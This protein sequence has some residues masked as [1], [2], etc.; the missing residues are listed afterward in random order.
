MRIILNLL[1]LVVSSSLIGQNK[2]KDYTE[3]FNLIEV[4]LDA[5]KDYD[6][7]PGITLAVIDDQEVM[8]SGAFGKASIEDDV[9]S[10]TRTLGSI[11]SISKLFT[12]VAIMKLYDEGKIRLDDNIEDLLPWF[13][14]QQQYK[15][16]GPIT[17]RSLMTHSSGL[18]R[19]A[20]APY[21]TGPDFPF[22]SQEEVKEGL[23]NQ[24]TLYPAS[25]YSQYSNLG[26][27]LLGE[28]V[29]E[30]SGM[31]YDEYINKQIL[32]PLGMSSTKTYMPED[33][34]GS[35]LAIGYSSLTREGE[36]KKV[37]L[38]Q[39][40]G[41]RAAAGY[42]SNVEDLGKFASWQFRVLDSTITEVLKPSTL[43]NMH[44]VH[45][46]DPGWN[47]TWGLGFAVYKGSDG[48]KWVAHGGSCPGY[49]STL[50]I[51]PK[52]KKAYVAMINSSGTNPGKYTSGIRSI[53]DKVKTG[54]ATVSE[55]DTVEI[56]DFSD[57]EGY[58]SSQPWWGETYV[59]TWEDKLVR[60]DLPTDDPGNSMT[61]FKH[62]EGDTFRRIRKDDELGEAL[63]F[64]RD[65]NGQV[66]KLSSHGNYSSKIDRTMN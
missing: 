20:L 33:L 52:K 54:K 59:S 31:T 14:L 49:R 27:T 17:V 57:Y 39:A 51:N 36:R 5:Q 55:S 1:L 53:I 66:V 58:Y 22:P 26:L 24:E 13:N 44:N 47:T 35:D 45:W 46:T 48:N 16:S 50:Q 10:S 37:Q 32:E 29:E 11:C 3:A 40:D 34:Y 62:I 64:H 9:A 38:F 43:R 12:A 56:A 41:I 19:E 4:W 61:F 25:T 60:L 18:P 7:L 30:V 8:W 63:I 2:E 65:E 15:D 28:I 6:K 42:S 21:W 23:S